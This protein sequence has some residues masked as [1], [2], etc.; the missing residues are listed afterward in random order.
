MK[1]YYPNSIKAKLDNIQHYIDMMGSG[2][3]DLLNSSS[4]ITSTRSNNNN[5][6]QSSA[7]SPII[8]WD[9]H[10]NKCSVEYGWLAAHDYLYYQ[11]TK[12]NISAK[13]S[14]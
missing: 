14:K 3:D 7:Y 4:I 2:L 5:M 12:W 8:Q 13:I 11:L 10:N 6:G 1:L 9:N